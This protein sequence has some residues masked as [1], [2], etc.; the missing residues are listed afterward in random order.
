M[1][2]K[3][4]QVVSSSVFVPEGTYDDDNQNIDNDMDFL[5]SLVQ[6]DMQEVKPQSEK[7]KQENVE[8]KQKIDDMYPFESDVHIP[9]DKLRPA[10]EEW[11][12]FPAQNTELLAELMAN[13]ATYGQTDP[14]RV[15]K[16]EDG[17]YIILG[18]HNRYQAL[19]NLHQLY[20]SGDVEMDH[21]FNTMWCSVYDTETLDEIEA[22]KIVIYDNTIRRDNTKALQRRSIIN[23]NQLMKETRTSRRP[24]T[25]REKISEQIA[26][27]MNV[28]GRTIRGILKLKKLIPEFWP[29][30][31]ETDKTKKISDGFAQAVS[32]LE[33][34]I[35]REIFVSK[36]YE[37]N[38]LTAGQLKTL[39]KAESYDDVQAVFT[40]PSKYTVSAK[41]E[42]ISP[43]PADVNTFV[44]CA[45][46]EEE[47]LLKKLIY[48]TVMEHS[49]FSETTKKNIKM[50][51]EC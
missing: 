32:S 26:E 8:R 27:V 38:K 4:R 47:E 30:F 13:I 31:D 12:F 20:I 11:N 16:Q 14:A 23:M 24:D 39:S 15:W 10:P 9:L 42:L 19:S 17:T 41:K 1:S 49:E 18:G 44:C 36:I 50:L 35:Q 25:K 34:D 22:R 5:K 48:K 7:Q 46:P 33:P 28:S 45:A 21:D 3:N 43:L 6:K 51:F 40:E 29:L 2:K 37:G